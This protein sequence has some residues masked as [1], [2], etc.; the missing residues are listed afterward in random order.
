[1]APL[2]ATYGHFW[3][4]FYSNIWSHWCFCLSQAH[5]SGFDVKL[6]K[7]V[8]ITLQFLEDIYSL[9]H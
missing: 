2:W 8:V 4:T 5:L 7:G 6:P 9:L 1:M 3:A